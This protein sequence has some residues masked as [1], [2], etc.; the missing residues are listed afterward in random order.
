MR[1]L[2]CPILFV[3]F[4]FVL[5]A[6]SPGVAKAPTTVYTAAL[7]PFE[8]RGPEVKGFGDKVA[9]LLFAFLMTAPNLYLVDRADLDKTLDEMEL[10]LSGAV[11]PDQA[12]QIGQLTGAKLLITGSVIPADDSLYILAKVI[13]TE[14]TRTLGVRVVG[15]LRSGLPQLVEELGSQ[16]SSLVS[17]RADELVGKESTMG[18]R[19]ALL[20]KKLGRASRPVVMVQI[21]ERH[22]GQPPIDPAA[23]T[24]I[25][26]LLKETGFT[27]VDPESGLSNEVDILIEGEGFSE[28]AVRRGDLVSVKARLEVKATDRETRNLIAV[29]RQTAVVVDLTEQLAGKK[30]L[31]KAAVAIA[32]RLLPKLVQK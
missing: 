26:M 30:A 21:T 31:Q 8:E 19:V 3:L 16:V 24:E 20:N 2:R 14:T 32:E 22:V 11:R 10:N 12:I 18:D 7:F 13:G 25:A 9:D 17:E 4:L 1:T 23:E 15:R 27:V 6:I 5:T 28:F 29:D